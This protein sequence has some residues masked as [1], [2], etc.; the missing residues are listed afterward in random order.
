MNGELH[1]TDWRNLK[2]GHA[3][4][5]EA[6]CDQP[7][8]VVRGDGAWV[9]VMTTG[10]GPEGSTGQHI[11]STISRDRG[12]TW[13]DPVDIEPAGPPEA[14]WVMPLLV[15]SGRIYAFYTYNG[16]NLRVVRT[17]PGY[18]ELG[19]RVDTLGQY[20][21]KYTDD[22]GLTWSADRHIIPVR[23]FAI[24]EA[25]PYGG[26]VRFFWG[27]GKPVIVGG[28]V[29]IGFSKVGRFG[30]GF[31]A[32]D[33]GAFLMS[34]NILSEPDPARI[35]WETLPDG[36]VGLRAPRS[37]IADEHNLVALSDGSLYCTY[38]TTEAHNCHAYSR[39]GGRT[40]TP[41]AYACYEP[42]GR[43]LKHPRAANFVRK[44]SNGK[45]T[46]WF[47]N[48][49]RDMTEEPQNAYIGRNPA[50]LIGGVEKDGFL[51]W[52][53]PEIVLY[54]DDPA[55]GI[56]YPDFIEDDGHYYITE[57]QKS[58]AR[59]H[60]VDP[61][62]LEGMWA[63]LENCTLTTVGLAARWQ[64]P[65][66][67]LDMPTLPSLAAGGGFTLELRMGLPVLRGGHVLLDARDGAGRGVLVT[68]TDRH[69]VALLL[70]DGK[71]A[72]WWDCDEGLLRA[73]QEHHVAIVVD[74]GPRIIGFVVDGQYCDGGERR[75]Y[76]WGRFAGELDDVNGAARAAV[77][78]GVAVLRVYD[79]A[80]HTYEAVA[81]FRSGQ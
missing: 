21:F 25:N 17:D 39:D 80:L 73:G 49:G 32:V 44:Y 9:C 11:I 67:S 7:Y 57:T 6:Y 33:E 24:D 16:D 13:S 68:V 41:P 63:H 3:L 81:N 34:D 65:A 45:F 55:I 66:E 71:T 52:S 48:H 20:A 1:S 54:D 59:V 76:G 2:N 64:P 22:G 62:L 10:W 40:W 4:P 14:S 58:I 79:R 61:T 60:A 28:R 69:T 8:V 23:P 35:R 43:L 30:K 56:S 31:M 37:A 36:K 18:E 53:Q 70:H 15:P 72:A 78:D 51:H 47:H 74:G 42:G 75:D 27:V 26:E 12:L 5:K 77:S 46:L 29:Y 38:R 50:W 19:T